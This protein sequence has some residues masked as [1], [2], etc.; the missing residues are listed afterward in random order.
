MKVLKTYDDFLW[1]DVT[2]IAR[3]LWLAQDFELYAIY[4]DQSEHL[5]NTESEFEG[6]INDKC[7]I[8]IELDYI[9]QITL[10]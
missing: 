3:S 2:E 8:A 10:I 9:D 5:I 4:D 7:I 1:A 6:T